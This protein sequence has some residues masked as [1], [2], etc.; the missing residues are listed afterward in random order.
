QVPALAQRA[1]LGATIPLNVQVGPNQYLSKINFAAM[2][3]FEVRKGLID[4]SGDYINVNG[5]MGRTNVT[6]IMGPRGG[7]VVPLNLNTSSHLASSIWDAT[8]GFSVLHGSDG[9]FVA[10]GG[11]RN[12]PITATLSYNV[13]TARLS[14]TGGA[15]RTDSAQ[16]WIWGFKGKALFG[17]DKKWFVP[18]YFDTGLGYTNATYQYYTGVGRVFGQ[19]SV[20]LAWRSLQYD[21]ANYAQP[22]GLIRRL[23]FDGPMVGYTFSL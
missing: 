2:G 7:L 12:F 22:D 14:R 4:V 13:A 6:Q 21:A 11:Y 9:D 20:T 10:F 15:S 1:G 5:S 19:N 3:S 23:R 18:Y 8:V 16:D 17:G